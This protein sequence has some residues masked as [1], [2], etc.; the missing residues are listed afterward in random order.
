M[1]P[2]LCALTVL[3]I[4][5]GPASLANAKPIYASV[6]Q[7]VE[8]RAAATDEARERADG[9]LKTAKAAAARGNWSGATKGYLES[10][11]DW[12]GTEALSG[13]ALGL[14]WIERSADGCENGFRI[15]LSD[16]STALGYLVLLTQLE[17]A[18]GEAFDSSQI[19]SA[20][21]HAQ[22]DTFEKIAGCAVQ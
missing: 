10:A 8:A 17:K 13:I 5:V 1:K 14:A 16:M 22:T 21:A 15:K 19:R 9:F 6:G 18:N 4:A 20:L 11:L 3:S 2:V 7:V 12:P